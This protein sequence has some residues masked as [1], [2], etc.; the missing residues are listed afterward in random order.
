MRSLLLLILASCCF[1]K[2]EAALPQNELKILVLVIASD[3]LPVYK[4]LQ[5]I[6]KSYMHLDPDHVEAYFIRGNP[7]LSTDFEI[8]ED[9]IWS[10]TDENVIPG[11]LRKTVLSLEAL[12]PR[13]EEF[14][15][16]LRTNLSSFYIFPRLLQF[17][18]TLP[19]KECY[20][21]FI[22]EAQGIWYGSGA[23]F[24][25]SKDLVQMLVRDRQ[26]IPNHPLHDDVL[27]GAFFQLKQIPVLP[28]PRTDLP[29]LSEWFAIKDHIPANAFHFRVKNA[30]EHLRSRDEVFIQSELVKMFYGIDSQAR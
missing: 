12:L 25:L 21:A 29:T 3:D 1:L 24:I 23:G 19:K 20:C 5:A 22:G 6:W 26:L 8:Q 4:E 18:H 15:Y 16:V 17:L 13:I 30:Y 2:V 10:K 7:N 9:V 27:I 28:A 14:D 11:I